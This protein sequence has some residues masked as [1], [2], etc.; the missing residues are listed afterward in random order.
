MSDLKPCPFCCSDDWA[1]V[2]YD[3]D[4]GGYFLQ[5]CGTCGAEVPVGKHNNTRPIEDA[6][7]AEAERLKAE[8]AALKPAP[9][10]CGECGARVCL[11]CGRKGL[12]PVPCPECGMGWSA[13]FPTCRECGTEMHQEASADGPRLFCPGCGCKP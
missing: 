1:T 6:L 10:T 3:G 7:R 4:H 9:P 13:C 8:L 12:H 5:A 2:D 11:T